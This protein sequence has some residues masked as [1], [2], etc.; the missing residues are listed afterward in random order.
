MAMF[1]NAL[2]ISLFM[3]GILFFQGT[4]QCFDEHK[5]YSKEGLSTSER[6]QLFYVYVTS[7]WPADEIWTKMSE[8]M[9]IIG[10]SNDTISRAAIDK[11]VADYSE[12]QYLSA[13]L[14]ETGTYCR[15]IKKPHIGLE[16]HQRV[17]DNWPSQ[18]SAMW[19]LREVAM[20][21]SSLAT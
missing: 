19:S 13:A 18:D 3:F 10:D 6:A 14:L 17:I 4:A 1:R 9:A 15:F 8:T 16:L 21:K 11:L 5:Y 2:S 20:L 12:N 7:K